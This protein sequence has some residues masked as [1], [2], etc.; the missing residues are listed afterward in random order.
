VGAGGGKEEKSIPEAEVR[1]EWRRE[2][3]VLTKRG[4]RDT[5]ARTAAL[6]AWKKA[7]PAATGASSRRP[8]T[9]ISNPTDT[10]HSTSVAAKNALV[11]P[12]P[13]APPARW[14][15]IGFVVDS[16]WRTMSRTPQDR[17]AARSA[18]PRPLPLGPHDIKAMGRR[19]Y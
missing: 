16:S 4:S 14:G 7:K 9:P 18:L 1:E 19:N 15:G 6:A 17:T 13:A 10:A 5:D 11:S 2:T 3:A 8:R 12:P